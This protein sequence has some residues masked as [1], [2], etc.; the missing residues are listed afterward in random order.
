MARL[1]DYYKTTVV[2]EL[3]QKFGYKSKWKCRASPRSP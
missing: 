1:L 2:P 3:D